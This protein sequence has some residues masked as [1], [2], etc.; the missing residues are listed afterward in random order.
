MIRIEFKPK[1][2]DR[3]AMIAYK[4]TNWYLRKYREKIERNIIKKVENEI[5]YGKRSVGK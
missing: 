3:A 1:G 2:R 4:V 5:I